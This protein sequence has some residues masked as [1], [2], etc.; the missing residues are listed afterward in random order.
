MIRLLQNTEIDKEKWDACISSSPNE[1]I[2]SKS[3]YL[4]NISP[5][6]Q[7]LVLDD[8]AALMAI[9]WRKKWQ[10]TYLY[11]PSFIQQGGI[12]S[13][14]P[15][16]KE[17]IKDFIDYM[18]KIFRFGE[19]T[20]NYG[21]IIEANS[22]ITCNYRNNFIIELSSSYET[23]KSKYKESF[24]KNLNRVKGFGL[25]YSTSNN[26][27]EIIDLYERLYGSR[28]NYFSKKDYR[29]FGLLCKFMQQKGNLIIRKIKDN[30]DNLLAAV[31]ILKDGNRL[32]NMVSCLTSEGRKKEGNY[33][34]YDRIINEF[35]SSN[36]ILDLEGSDIQPI[37]DFYQRMGPIG[38]PYP[39]VKFNRLPIYI[40]YFKP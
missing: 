22:D 40:R 12:F 30:Q 6:W 18:L 25:T 10:I 23:L 33:F 21:N 39:F 1:L 19:I 3:F 32:Y 14:E 28:L 9:T 16:S 5:E 38:Q 29:K 20:F 8:Y 26:F 24:T 11:Q 17:I 35:S 34:L 7:G 36:F 37:A 13:K 31:I 15:L 27:I 2:Y 4:D